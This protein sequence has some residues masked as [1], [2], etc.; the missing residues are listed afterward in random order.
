MLLILNPIRV[1]TAFGVSNSEAT[2]I[3]AYNVMN[4]LALLGVIA[5]L[6][7]LIGLY[8]SQSE[9]TG[10]LGLVGFL[11]AFIGTAQNVGVRWAETFV[12]P[13]VAEV[14]PEWVDDPNHGMVLLGTKLGS[15][16]LAAGWMVFGVA[17]LRAGVYPRAAAI[18]LVIGMVITLATQHF[19]QLGLLMLVGRITLYGA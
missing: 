9:A 8:A 19:P 3:W 2:T 5:T 16:I 17:T 7:G 13:S 1:G 4:G 14:S 11:V 18:A 6:M 10:V 15:W 12:L